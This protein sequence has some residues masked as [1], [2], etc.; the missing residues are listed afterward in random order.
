MGIHRVEEVIVYAKNN[1]ITAE[2]YSED[3]GDIQT[4]INELNKSLPSYKRIQRV[5]FR[6]IPFEKT[7]TKKIKRNT[8]P[9]AQ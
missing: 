9:Q 7:T 4:A 2:I 1:I 5:I 8:L 3:H 6:D